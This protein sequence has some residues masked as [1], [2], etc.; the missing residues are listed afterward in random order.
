MHN[1]DTNI[2]TITNIS[3][4]NTSIVPDLASRKFGSGDTKNREI[5]GAPAGVTADPYEFNINITYVSN[6]GVTNVQ[7]G[8]KPL[9]GRYS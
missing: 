2:L 1:I 7:Y 3:L 6:A 9:V 8:V 4:D 5:T